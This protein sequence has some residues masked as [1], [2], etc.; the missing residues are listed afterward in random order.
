MKTQTEEGSGMKVIHI[1][2]R[3]YK[4]K[5]WKRGY[6][7]VNGKFADPLRGTK[8]HRF[9]SAQMTDG[10]TADARGSAFDGGSGV[11][12][13]NAPKPQ[14]VRM[15]MQGGELGFENFD[16][17]PIP[18]PNWVQARSSDGAEGDGNER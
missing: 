17:D 3:S 4:P 16:G 8:N 2:T 18:M 12:K 5:E 11:S 10:D 14:W 15:K 7:R 1:M 13:W 6:L 9:F